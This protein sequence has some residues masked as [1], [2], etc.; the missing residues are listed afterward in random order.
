MQGLDGAM[1]GA[2]GIPNAREEVADGVGHWHSVVC[3]QWS[4]IVTPPAISGP[5]RLM[6]WRQGLRKYGKQRSLLPACLP[7]AG[8]LAF[9]RKL[10]QDVSAQHKVPID[11]APASGHRTAIANT[12]GIAIARKLLERFIIAC[13]L[14]RGS[15]GCI[16]CH[17]PLSFAITSNNCIG[18]HRAFN[19]VSLSCGT[20]IQT[21]GA[22]R[23]LPRR[24][25]R[26]LR[27]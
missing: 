2:L 12:D 26:W 18:C 21:L 11:A 7:Q 14:E 15:L 13:F 17:Q 24:S 10:P 25:V 1:L 27:T 9:E 16:L 23:M 4:N 22:G 5:F 20:E 6:R 3:T 19:S 8:D